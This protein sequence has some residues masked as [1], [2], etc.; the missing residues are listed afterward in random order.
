MRIILEIDEAQDVRIQT[1]K[2][3]KGAQQQGQEEREEQEEHQASAPAVDAGN[4]P[5]YDGATDAD[6]DSGP[7]MTIAAEAGMEG[8]GYV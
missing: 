8:D 2:D 5:G 3:R 7:Y 6:A 1:V 4:A